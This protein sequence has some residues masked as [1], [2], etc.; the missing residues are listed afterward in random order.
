MSNN[1]ITTTSEKKGTH[2]LEFKINDRADRHREP[3]THR[4]NGH[5]QH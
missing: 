4:M 5:T 3:R 1:N 2:E